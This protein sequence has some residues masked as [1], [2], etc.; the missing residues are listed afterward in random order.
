MR[1]L[2]RPGAPARPGTPASCRLPLVS[3]LRVAL[4]AGWVAVGAFAER[5]RADGRQRATAFPG[6]WLPAF[7]LVV[8]VAW[9]VAP[10]ALAQAPGATGDGFVWRDYEE[11]TVGP[12][13]PLWQQA[14][15]FLLKLGFVI[16]LAYASLLMY[17]RML[18]T[19]APLGFGRIRVLENTRL[20]GTQSL[21]MVQVGDQIMLLG[22]NGA[23]LLVKLS[24]WPADQPPPPQDEAVFGRAVN[25][26]AARG[27]DFDTV[28]E[29]S[30]KQAVIPPRDNG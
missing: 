29:S 30:L 15:W 1:A 9:L 8:A 24:E 10:D 7:L 19:R 12:S 18:G 26:A 23:G 22:S 5:S 14:L 16:G 17:K 6:G 3:A 20:A 13:E 25:Q 27:D 2:P 11:P 21:Y 28:I 4:G